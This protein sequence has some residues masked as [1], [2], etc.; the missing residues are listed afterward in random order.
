MEVVI[1]HATTPRRIR[2][3]NNAVKNLKFPYEGRDR[4]GYSPVFPY[5][6]ELWSYKMKKE[7]VP[8]F[9][10]FVQANTSEVSSSPR[11]VQNFANFAQ[12][13]LKLI[14]NTKNY[15]D[16]IKCRILGKKR[17]TK[18]NIIIPNMKKV[19][20]SQG[21]VPGWGYSKVLLAF[22]DHYNQSGE[23]EL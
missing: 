3:F 20:R 12:F 22:P 6:M 9:L 4:S 7:V 19:P 13:W 5:K 14:A 8:E 15:Y 11:P 18:N 1:L 2:E 16:E 10:K 21:T 23:E 17:R